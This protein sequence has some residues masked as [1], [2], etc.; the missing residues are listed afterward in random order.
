[1]QV[2]CPKCSR[3]ILVTDVIESS[4][5]RFSHLDCARSHGLTPEERSLLFVY[6]FDHVVARCVSCNLAFRMTEL[7]ADALGGGRTNLCPG[8]RTDLTEKVRAHLF[9]CMVLPSELRQKTQDVRDAAQRLIKRSQEAI[10]KSDVLVREAE[11]HLLERQ[12]ALRAAM[13]RRVGDK[14]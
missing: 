8:C 5:D 11:A 2:N 13:A 1:M 6:C 3:P 4:G 14:K 12:Q 7:A 9:G 10:D